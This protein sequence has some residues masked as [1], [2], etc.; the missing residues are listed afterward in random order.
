MTPIAL[1]LAFDP[2]TKRMATLHGGEGAM[3]AAVKGAPEMVVACSTRSG[4]R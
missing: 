2:D 4:S 3:V 1:E